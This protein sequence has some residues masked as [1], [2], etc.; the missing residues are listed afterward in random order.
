MCRMGLLEHSRDTPNAC[1]P[2]LNV[3]PV[4]ED[5]ELCSKLLRV[6]LKKMTKTPHS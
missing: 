4:M 5:E 3:V 1:T 2:G 6:N